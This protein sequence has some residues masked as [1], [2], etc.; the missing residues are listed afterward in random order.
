MNQKI[1]FVDD[2]ENILKSLKRDMS[3]AG[4]EAEY[5]NSAT[6]ALEYLSRHQI[7]IVVS[8]LKMPG[9]DGIAFL[10]EVQRSYPNIYRVLLSGFGSEDTES[11][12]ALQDR[13]IEQ[14]FFKPWDLNEL[15]AYFG[16]FA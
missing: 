1:I 16:R 5:F 3:M 4:V 14:C 15:L 2:E 7:N 8:D 6:A 12:K 11:I 9:M 13:T 10:K